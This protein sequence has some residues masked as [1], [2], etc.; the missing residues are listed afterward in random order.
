M[1]IIV[2]LGNPG[3]KYQY[4]R[5]NVGFLA[6]DYLAEKN[7]PDKPHWEENKK[8]KALIFKHHD[9]LF[10]KPLTFMNN[11]GQTVRAVLD[12]YKLLPKR[13]GLLKIKN[14]DLSETLTVIQ[15]EVDLDLGKSKISINSGSAG[16]RGIESI[17]A[18]LKTKN[19]RRLRIGINSPLRGRIPTESFVLQKFNKQELEI[20]N[21]VFKN[22]EL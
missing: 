10:I 13:L 4:T 7:C 15:D 3:E 17:I 8:L 22:I 18:H 1:K 2:G 5:H 20:I 21:E 16:H 19:F 14:S 12:Y 11:S 6:L 9:Q